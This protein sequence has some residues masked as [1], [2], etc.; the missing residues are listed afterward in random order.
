[1]PILDDGQFERYLKEF[2]PLA[3]ASLQIEKQP[4]AARRPFVLIAWAAACVAS[5][6]LAFLLVSHRFRSTKPAGVLQLAGSQ[7]L[8][9][10]RANA[11]L[12]QAPSVNAAVD[13][14]SFQP[15]PAPQSEGK[16]SALA[17]LGKENIKL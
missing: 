9:I 1:V 14:L 13:Q 12:A 2:H 7:S 11:L 17:V 10:G 4:R 5:L 6:V 15:Q 16:Q 8:T 3:P